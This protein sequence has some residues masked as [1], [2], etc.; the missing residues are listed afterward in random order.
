MKD[1]CSNS[2]KTFFKG[3]IATY[4]HYSSVADLTNVS[5][6]WIVHKKKEETYPSITEGYILLFYGDKAGFCHSYVDN[7]QIVDK[8]V[9]KLNNI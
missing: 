9:R 7:S 6:N 5:L 3:P 4:E 1:L 8:Q 2:S